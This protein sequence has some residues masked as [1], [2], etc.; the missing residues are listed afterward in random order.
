VWEPLMAATTRPPTMPANNPENASAPDAKAMPKH[1]GNATRKTTSPDIKSRT[2]VDGENNVVEGEPGDACD[3][4]LFLNVLM[5]LN[6]ESAEPVHCIS[7]N[8]SIL[9]SSIRENSESNE[10]RLNSQE[11]SCKRVRKSIYEAAV[12][13][14]SAQAGR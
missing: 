10:K 13:T 1:S 9:R 3:M 12:N 6:G 2:I 11:F 5:V 7:N 8:A 4:F 14:G